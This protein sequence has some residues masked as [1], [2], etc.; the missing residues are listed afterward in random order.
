MSSA[1]CIT[2]AKGNVSQDLSRSIKKIKNNF[3]KSQ[4][5]AVLLQNISPVK[6]IKGQSLS[7][8]LS[9]VQGSVLR[10]Q[11]SVMH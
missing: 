7:A 2:K 6:T 9:T 4:N 8:Q 10:S 3:K 1:E 5:I 11:K